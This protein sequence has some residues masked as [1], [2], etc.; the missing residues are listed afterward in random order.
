MLKIQVHTFMQKTQK[1][2]VVYIFNFQFLAITS[3]FAL[4][5]LNVSDDDC[6]IYSFP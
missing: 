3:V 5:L 1:L 6:I 4:Y 2:Q